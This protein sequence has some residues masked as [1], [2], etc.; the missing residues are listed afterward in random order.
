[1]ATLTSRQAAAAL[2]VRMRQLALRLQIHTDMSRLF[3]SGQMTCAMLLGAGLLLRAQAAL[4]PEP[5]APA[6][7]EEPRTRPSEMM[8]ERARTAPRVVRNEALAAPRIVHRSS[9][10]RKGFAH[11]ARRHRVRKCGVALARRAF[12]CG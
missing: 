7:L 8:G 1:M 6:T 12:R 11:R 4:H 2:L 10:T 9:H 5:S 3:L